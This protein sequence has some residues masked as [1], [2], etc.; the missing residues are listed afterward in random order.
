MAVHARIARY[1]FDNYGAARSGD[2]IA[3]C[4]T[5]H[6]DSGR[7]CDVVWQPRESDVQGLAFLVGK[8]AKHA[9]GRRG[10]D[11]GLRLMMVHIDEALGTFEGNA[12]ELIVGPRDVFV[13]G[14]R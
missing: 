2:G 1:L 10:I 4:L 13:R 6:S 9:M 7:T 14:V 5:L 8:D 12:G 3:I 11:G